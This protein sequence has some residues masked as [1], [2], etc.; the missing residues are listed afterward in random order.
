MPFASRRRKAVAKLED[1]RHDVEVAGPQGE[2]TH[3][4]DKGR[5]EKPSKRRTEFV[6]YRR[7][8]E[9]L[10]AEAGFIDLGVEKMVKY[11]KAQR[12]FFGA[13]E[14]EEPSVEREGLPKSHR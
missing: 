1:A 6:G 3:Y 12:S 14:P 9:W 8:V 10:Q 4:D 5:R 11:I 13:S 7:Y 2:Q